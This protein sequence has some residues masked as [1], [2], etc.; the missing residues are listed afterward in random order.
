MSEKL[1]NIFYQSHSGS[2]A[3]LLILFVVAFLLAKG[4]KAKGAKIVGMVL[5]LFYIIMLV[6][7]VGMLIGFSFPL[8]FIIKG[9]LAVIL[10]GLME[11]ILGRTQRRENTGMFWILLV[12]IV[13]IV[14]LMG[15]GVISF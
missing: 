1:I 12:I 4:G 6:S 2:W 3:F 8:M 13:A 5:R 15:F 10:I 14:V 11:M 9:I 7:G